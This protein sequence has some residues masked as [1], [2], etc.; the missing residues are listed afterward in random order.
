[1]TR[2][3]VLA[4]RI[5]MSHKHEEAELNVVP[6]LVGIPIMTLDSSRCYINQVISYLQISAVSVGRPDM[7][8]G[9]FSIW[10]L[11]QFVQ[12]VA[13]GETPVNTAS[14][15]TI[16]SIRRLL[17]SLFAQSRSSFSPTID[18]RQFHHPV[19]LF[20]FNDL[21]TTMINSSLQGGE[22]LDQLRL[23]SILISQTMKVMFTERLL[24]GEIKEKP[25]HVRGSRV[26]VYEHE[27][28]LQR[29]T[30]KMEVLSIL[31]S[32]LSLDVDQTQSALA[33]MIGSRTHPRDIL[34]ISEYKWGQVTGFSG[35][36]ASELSMPVEIVN[37]I[38]DLLGHSTEHEFYE[39]MMNTSLHL[40]GNGQLSSLLPWYPDF[41]GDLP[42]L[43]PFEPLVGDA[44][45]MCEWVKTQSLADKAVNACQNK[46]HKL[47]KESKR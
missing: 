15:H 34:S 21:P 4:Q 33:R 16:V 41:K 27:K 25:I 36:I 13:I 37:L 20:N 2:E 19:T 14:I 24:S 45:T 31:H 43:P 1:M 12:S 38:V 11:H 46:L 29:C 22:H 47:E 40:I 26:I 6:D 23:T 3:N 5:D 7:S 32:I 18:H 17:L 9:D 30:Q 8:V 28:V 35:W 42:V 10:L 44:R 39:L